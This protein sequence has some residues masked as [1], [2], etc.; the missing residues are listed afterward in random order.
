MIMHITL[1]GSRPKG[2]LAL[3]RQFATIR[4]TWISCF[5]VVSVAPIEKTLDSINIEGAGHTSGVSGSLWDGGALSCAACKLGNAPMTEVKMRSADVPN[6]RST[7]LIPMTIYEQR[8]FS[9]W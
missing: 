5:S 4:S 7:K 9:A 3:W 8:Y 6:H 2:V 1:G